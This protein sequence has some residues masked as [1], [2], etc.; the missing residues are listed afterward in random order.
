MT[1][2]TII[3][4]GTDADAGFWLACRPFVH[5]PWIEFEP[6]HEGADRLSDSD[7]P[8]GPSISFHDHTNSARE[9]HDHA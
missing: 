4:Y 8:A 1:L 3:D 6:V 9:A 5:F 2:P 7:G